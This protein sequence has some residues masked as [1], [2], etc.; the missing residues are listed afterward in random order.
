MPKKI[1]QTSLENLDGIR[2]IFLPDPIPM[3]NDFK[4]ISTKFKNT[5]ISE[6]YL[7][8]YPDELLCP[9]CDHPTYFEDTPL[10]VQ[11]IFK[12]DRFLS[13]LKVSISQRTAFLTLLA[14]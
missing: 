4:I 3:E 8:G 10:S 7:S 5:K 2:E 1:T 14:L 13:V 11:T 9:Y 6:S 12:F